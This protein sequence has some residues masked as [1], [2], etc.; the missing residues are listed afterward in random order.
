MKMVKEILKFF[1]VKCKININIFLN[2]PIKIICGAGDSR[3]SGWISTN[4]NQF[5][6]LK[7]NLDEKNGYIFRS[8]NNDKRNI[9]N[10]IKYT[11]LILDLKKK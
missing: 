8:L 3:Y 10:K 7:E 6:L 9:D 4:I 2:R 11:S 1:L 5:N